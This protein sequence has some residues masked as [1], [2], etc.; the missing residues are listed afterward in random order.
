MMCVGLKGI[1]T[2]KE[3]VEI[4][5]FV[6]KDV[7]PQGFGK[8]GTVGSNGEGVLG[9]PDINE[10]VCTEGESKRDVGVERGG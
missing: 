1:V 9:A 6:K 2:G 8:G 10:V 4:N 5:V 7:G 3:V